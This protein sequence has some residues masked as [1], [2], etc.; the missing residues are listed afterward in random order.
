MRLE[1]T[2]KALQL[3]MG[4]WISQTLD[5]KAFILLVQS[6]VDHSCIFPYRSLSD[7]YQ[8]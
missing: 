8:I 5:T 1:V 6:P 7:L 2:Y 4:F 3:T